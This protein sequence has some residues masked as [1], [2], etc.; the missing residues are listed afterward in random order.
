[1]SWR[2]VYISSSAHL[3]FKNNHLVVRTEDVTMIHLSEIHSI[4]VESLE[5]TIS[6]YLIKELNKYKVKL[7]FCDEKHNPVSELISYYGAFNAS[8]MIDKSLSW[9]KEYCDDLW[10]IIVRY[11]IKYQSRLL[12]KYNDE[13]AKQIL[14][15]SMEVVA[16]DLTNR[17]GHA[18]KVYF[19][20]LFG[21]NFS[22]DNECDIN[23]ALNY[24]Y[25]IILSMFNREIVN[26]GFLT[27]T[28]IHHRGGTNPFNLSCDL[29]EILR[30]FVDVYVKENEHR[31]FD[32]QYKL[33]LIEYI[34]SKV[35][36]L[37]KNQYVSQ[38]ISMM[39]KKVLDGITNCEVDEG[40]FVYGEQ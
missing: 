13:I 21:K 20:S 1:M 9:T 22:R 17:E 2:T 6:S 27:Q 32:R 23:A 8:K 16:G 3:S 34:N 11:K 10:A 28:G 33:N 30:P 26:C 38:M 4:I 37:G 15:Y 39:T 19:N 29:M 14:K 5:V 7:I 36:Y 31:E 25:A 18:A 24:G 12:A 40:L 35:V